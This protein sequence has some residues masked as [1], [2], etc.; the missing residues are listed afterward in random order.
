[1]SALKDLSGQR[2]GRLTVIERSGSDH[3]G[4]AT[5]LCR[6]DCGKEVVIRGADMRSGRAKSCGCM[7]W[8]NSK[9]VH[10]K[11][12]Q[13]GTRLYVVWCSMK[14]RCYNSSNKSYERYGGRGITVCDEWLHDFQNFYKWAIESGYDEK[15][16]KG[17]CTIDRIDNNQGYNPDNCRWVDQKTQCSNREHSGPRPKNKKE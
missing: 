11:H 17:Q 10:I 3:K 1:M 5:W 13:A 9:K 2:F 7:F 4:L 8:I 15:A 14:D 12:G 6:C 16:P